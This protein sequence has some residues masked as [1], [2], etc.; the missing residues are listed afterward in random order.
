MRAGRVIIVQGIIVRR[1][2]EVNPVLSIGET[3]IIGQDTIRGRRNIDP[4]ILIRS[5]QIV[6]GVI[7]QG[8]T[9]RR[10]KIDSISGIIVTVIPGQGII[11]T[12]AGQLYSILAI[13][14]AGV[15]GQGIIIGTV[16]KADSMVSIRG[17]DSSAD[18]NIAGGIEIDAV[19][20]IMDFTVLDR[21]SAID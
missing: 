20:I 16:N 7:G 3:G 11:I 14:R 6:T 8:T 15:P 4:S 12:T 19:I 10:V 1:G 2:Y 21:E 9:D 17:A 13:A 5:S 18:G